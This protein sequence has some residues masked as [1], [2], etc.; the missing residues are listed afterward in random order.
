MEEMERE[1][2]ERET[3]MQPDLADGGD[4]GRKKRRE[5]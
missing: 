5:N 3:L 1:K 4:R 2:E